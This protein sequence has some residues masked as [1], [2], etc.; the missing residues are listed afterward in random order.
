[1]AAAIGLA[2]LALA[3][4]AGALASADP[5]LTP[6]Y[7]PNGFVHNERPASLIDETLAQ[8]ESFGIGQAILPMPKLKRDGTI[9]I[10]RKEARMIPLWV[11]RTAAYN[12]GHGTDMLLVAVFDGHTAGAGLDLEDPTVRAN[13]LASIETVLAM[14]VGGVQ[15]DFEPYPH[16]P[17]FVMLLEEID[18]AFAR[19]GFHGPLSVTAPAHLATWPPAYMNEVTAHLSEVDPLF[20]DGEFTSEAGYQRWIRE[21]LA[22]YSANTAPATRIIAMIPSYGPNRWHR[23][24]IEDV[25]SATTALGE[26]LQAGSRVSGAGVFWWWGFFYDEEG[27]YDAAADRAAWPATI[28]LPFTP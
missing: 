21:G 7:I 5:Q 1:M 6:T 16:S 26:A 19:L 2:A 8:L 25:A 18:Q 15:L 10:P 22:Y 13:V 17:G 12:A 14:G 9:K 24:A 3:L 27:A 20:Y 28:A 11:A 23:P 4:P